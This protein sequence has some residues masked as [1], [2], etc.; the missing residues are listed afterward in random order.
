MQPR[1]E[2]W[3]QLL[4]FPPALD[5]GDIGWMQEEPSS[6]VPRGLEPTIIN[7]RSDTVHCP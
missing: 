5:Q 2:V 1:L 7:T 3:G 4:L 6:P